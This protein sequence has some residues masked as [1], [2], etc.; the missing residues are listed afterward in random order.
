MQHTNV[1]P[2]GN[3]GGSGR[4][5]SEGLKAPSEDES[6][7]DA[8]E[9]AKAR[10]DEV[11]DGKRKAIRSPTP[12]DD[13][14][15]RKRKR[16]EGRVE[17]ARRKVAKALAEQRRM[18][19]EEQETK[20]RLAEVAGRTDAAARLVLARSAMLEREER[21]N[22]EDEDT[23]ED[24]TDDEDR[25]EFEAPNPCDQC[26]QYDEVCIVDENVKKCGQCDQAQIM[27]SLGGS[28]APSDVQVGVRRLGDSEAPS[29][30][31]P[32][33]ESEKKIRKRTEQIPACERCA[34]AKRDCFVQDGRTSCEYCVKAKGKCSL[35][36]KT[37]RTN[38]RE[39]AMKNRSQRSGNT[40][41]AGKPGRVR[42]A[43]VARRPARKVAESS[44]SESEIRPVTRSQAR[45]PWVTRK[46]FD[47]LFDLYKELAEQVQ[48]S[49]EVN[50]SRA[51]RRG[52]KKEKRKEKRKA[53]APA[54]VS[55]HVP[56][57]PEDE[58]SVAGREDRGEG[59]SGTVHVEPAP[60]IPQGPED[61]G[62]GSSGLA[63]VDIAP[64]VPAEQPGGSDVDMEEVEIPVKPEP[65]D[66]IIVPPELTRIVEVVAEEPPPVV[67][68]APEIAPETAPEEPEVKPEPEP[69]KIPEKKEKTAGTGPKPGQP[70]FEISDSE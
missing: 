55:D 70:I 18:E 42:K 68:A 9:V 57:G 29:E 61:H 64:E 19:Q 53:P 44:E 27:C 1:G 11:R 32:E 46:E 43:G 31:E 56:E 67:V 54:P 40:G 2:S 52:Q 60:E 62:E 14:R 49:S 5:P 3:A 34:K 6:S 23:E 28:E 13:A 36:P 24:E 51:A 33:P 58:G 37:S 7:P 35:N 25:S 4:R 50:K 66:I 20:R 15:E 21:R 10:R 45:G 22:T 41:T 17:R 8:R 48:G 26:R 69:A 30:P 63:G 38:K 12:E 39:E 59:G 47:H 16:K 65:Q